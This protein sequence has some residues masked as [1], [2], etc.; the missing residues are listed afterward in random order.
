MTDTNISDAQLSQFLAFTG[1]SDPNVARQYLEMSGNQLEMAVSLFM[2][3]NNTTAGGSGGSGGGSGGAAMGGGMM[4]SPEVRAPDATRSMR[5][6]G[7]P[8]SPLGGGRNNHNNNNNMNL[9]AQQAALMAA[10][11][12]PN[13]AQQMMMMGMMGGGGTNSNN[14]SNAHGMMMD[15]VMA[16]TWA[17]RDLRETVNRAASSSGNRRNRSG[18]S[19]G[20]GGGR[21]SPNYNNNDRHGGGGESDGSSSGGGGGRRSPNYNNNDRHGG[22]GG[23]GDYHNRR[24]RTGSRSRNDTNQD[25]DGGGDRNNH[26]HD[27]DDED[28]VQEVDSNGN[29]INNQDMEESYDDDDDED[30][31]HY[32]DQSDDDSMGGTALPSSSNN[33]NNNR[34]PPSLSTMFQPPNHLIHRAGGFLGA[35][36]FAKDARRWLLVNIQSED[37]FACH[38]LN[39]DVWHD[40]LVENLVREGFVFWQ[41]AS[42][43]PEGMTYCTRYKVEGRYPHIAILDPRTGSLLYRKEGWTQVNPLTAEQ[44]VEIASD[45]CS[46]HSFDRLPMPAR[47][48]YAANGGG[49]GGLGGE[50]SGSRPAKRPVHELSEQEQL[51]AAI[52]ASMQDAGG[53]AA[54]DNDDDDDNEVQVLEDEENGGG[55]IG[56]SIEDEMTPKTSA[57]E[58][59]KQEE[60]DN[61][62]QQKEEEESKL[63]PFEAEILSMTVP[64]EPTTTTGPNIAK[65]QLRMPNGKRLVRKFDGDLPVKVIYAYVVQLE[66]NI[67]DAKSGRQLDAKAKFPP[68]DLMPFVEESISSQEL[69][70]EAIT[71]LWK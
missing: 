13:A 11:G 7:G 6:V 66:S 42:T 64:D 57:Q 14:N 61:D 29:I 5:L 41:V 43:H 36:N 28:E 49:G 69:S 16:N 65:V 58:N 21:R 59:N 52:R 22:G 39:R 25:D 40:E 3:H 55:M 35:K 50:G 48:G 18:S 8:P 67:E 54:S 37:D 45:F 51:E 15:D 10:V 30:S 38:A 12:G 70:G 68:V 63:S 20:G 32:N 31:Y 27:D 62:K 53:Q 4:G 44:F 24:R 60:D 17:D 33:N 47:H 19:S 23:G 46:R 56:K 1:S 26:N 71:F 34:P 9:D 2:D